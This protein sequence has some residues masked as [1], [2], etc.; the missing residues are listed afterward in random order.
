MDNDCDGD[1]DEGA[2]DASTWYAD[3]DAD[4]YGDADTSVDSCEPPTALCT[5]DATDCDDLNASAHPGGTEVCDGADNDCDGDTD[6]GVEA[7]WY[8]DA[9]GDG[10]GDAS[11]GI[12]A[13]SA[14]SEAYGADA[15]DCDDLDASA[16][17]GGTEVCDGADNDCDG[18]TDEAGA[19][20]ESSWY[21]DADSDGY[22][23][24][25]TSQ[26]ACTAPSGHV[27]DSTDCDDGDAAV[28]PSA[29]EL[30]D[31][32]DNDCDGDTD[33]DDADDAASWYADADGYGDPDVT[34]DACEQPSGHASP[35][36][37][38][39]CDDSDAD[40]HPGATEVCDG[41]DNDCDGSSD[42]GMLGGSA[43]CAASSCDDIL[44][45]Q[46]TAIDGDYT[47]DP[48]GSG[49]A[50]Y[51]CD[52]TTDGGGWTLVLSWDRSDDG[53]SQADFETLMTRVYDNM[54]D[55]SEGDTYIQWSD[56][57]ATADVMS[58]DHEIEVPNDGEVLLDTYL[59]GYSYD[60][61]SVFL[62]AE[63]DGAL[64]E[65]VCESYTGWNSSG[66]AAWSSAE[67]AYWPYTCSDTTDGTLENDVTLR[68][69][70]QT[71][72]SGEVSTFNLTSFHYDSSYGDYSQ[73]YWLEVWVR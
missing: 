8:L 35:D 62:S 57:D 17:P 2:V 28:S 70:Y 16:H 72:H 51:A 34:M 43:D 45:D 42:D 68:G 11:A 63:V 39:D 26:D 60:D 4:G 30:C 61:S 41:L 36:E 53:D 56:V 73:L 10:Y 20:D 5:S 40:I 24:T 19:T 65:V 38:E 67:Q 14:P 54:T 27:A 6:E 55:W 52:M 31:G 37:G 49:A 9:D 25:S 29:D 44:A 71:A 58:Y 59:Y 7:S 48:D 15:T 1:I 23:D 3:R 18:D 50:T 33:E 46:P 47:L 13:C 64:E 69:P 66:L 21:A 12:E 22:G 32:V